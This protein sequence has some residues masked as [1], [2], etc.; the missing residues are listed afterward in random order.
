MTPDLKFLAAVAL[1]FDNPTSVGETA[2]GVRFDFV[3]HGTVM[4]PALKGK[5]HPAAAYLRIDPD[6]VGTIQVRA[7]LYLD[8][9]GLAE[10]EATGRCDFGEDGY[11]RAVAGDLPNAALGWCPRFLTGHPRHL[12][13]NRARCL[14]VGE[15]R[16]RETRVDYDLFQ[17]TPRAC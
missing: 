4:G 15:L 17:V 10:L 16:P 2:D 7:P 13:L 5:F 12:W 11:R 3:V 14:G 1:R 6:G 8:D 9:G